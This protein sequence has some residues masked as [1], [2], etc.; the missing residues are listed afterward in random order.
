MSNFQG[1]L[2]K[3]GDTIFPHKYLAKNPTFTPNQ[4]TEA[5]AYRDGNNDLHRV[6]IDN[7]KSKLEVTIVPDI[8]LEQKIEIENAMYSGLENIVERKYLITFWNDDVHVNDYRT[9]SVYLSDVSYSYTKIKNGTLYYDEITYT[10]V[11]Y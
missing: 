9:G 7:H 10:F 2:L 11:E 4:R 6:T 1:Y 8:T 5:E 3:F